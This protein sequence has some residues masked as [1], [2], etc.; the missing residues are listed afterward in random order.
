[1]ALPQLFTTGVSAVGSGVSNIFSGIAAGYTAQQQQDAA[2]AAEQQAAAA[3]TAAQGDI[4]Q[5]Q[6]D[7][8]ESQMYTTAAG[9]AT[10]QAEFTA[11]S[12]AI[13][14]AQA[15]RTLYMTL[16]GERA[17]AGGSGSSGR[18]SVTRRDNAPRF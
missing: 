6:G 18:G 11:Q 15:D 13:Q 16:G 4:L 12:T 7:V 2:L 1:L 3:R 9:L 17:A 5:G 8:I 14:K 10:Q